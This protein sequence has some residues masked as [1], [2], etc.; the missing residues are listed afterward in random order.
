MRTVAF[1]CF[2]DRGAKSSENIGSLHQSAEPAA[3]LPVTGCKGDR[4]FLYSKR[5]LMADLCLMRQ[6]QTGQ[7]I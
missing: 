4:F 7:L 6:A 5:L 2:A 1:V 3:L